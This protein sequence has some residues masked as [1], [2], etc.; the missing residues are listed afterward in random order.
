M[1]AFPIRSLI[2]L[3]LFQ[4]QVFA[5]HLAIDSPR[6][7]LVMIQH[8]AGDANNL[9]L[10]PDKP[11]HGTLPPGV[12]LARR[13]VLVPTRRVAGPITRAAA[14]ANIHITQD[15]AREVLVKA[16]PYLDETAAAIILAPTIQPP[17]PPSW[18][19]TTER[20]PSLMFITERYTGI[21]AE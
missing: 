8:T 3:Q 6:C 10:P 20:Y 15:E 19:P 11:P 14:E 5:D 4:T 13:Q 2:S 12:R 17:Q 1:A 9:D 21:A 18:E 7:L 16:D